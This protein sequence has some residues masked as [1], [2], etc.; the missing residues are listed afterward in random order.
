M[1]LLSAYKYAQPSSSLLFLSLHFPFLLLPSLC[2]PS[3]LSATVRG[4]PRAAAAAAAPRSQR[5]KRK[6]AGGEGS[7]SAHAAPAKRKMAGCGGLDPTCAGGGG[8]IAEKVHRCRMPPM[9]EAVGGRAAAVEEA[10]PVV[11]EER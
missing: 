10:E 4:G 6:R 7:D 3:L 9:E 11:E 8:G 2:F 1:S 5:A